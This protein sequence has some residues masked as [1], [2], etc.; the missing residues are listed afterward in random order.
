MITFYVQSIII[1]DFLNDKYT[2]ISNNF[3]AFNF[4]FYNYEPAKLSTNL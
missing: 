4:S 1:M 3:T 2:I